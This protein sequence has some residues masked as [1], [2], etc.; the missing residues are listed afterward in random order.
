MYVLH[1]KKKR[2]KTYVGIVHIEAK[3]VR[4]VPEGLG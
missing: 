4:H 3:L 2:K 1:K